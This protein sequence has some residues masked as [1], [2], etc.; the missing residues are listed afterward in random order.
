[1]PSGTRLYLGLIHHDDATGDQARIERAKTVVPVFGIAAECGW[2][3]ADPDRVPG[4]LESH[5]K[6]IGY[7]Q[8]A[9]S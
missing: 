4:L 3:R 2:G 8:S 6:A 9:V 7:L 1:M 5:R